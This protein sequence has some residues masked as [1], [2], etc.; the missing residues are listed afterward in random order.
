[1]IQ[2]L[3]MKDRPHKKSIEILKK[4]SK[5]PSME[6]RVGR[7]KGNRRNRP[8]SPQW[9]RVIGFGEGTPPLGSF[10]SFVFQLAQFCK[11]PKDFIDF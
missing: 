11:K 2:P 6:S 9:G 7:P 3:P 5:I 1:M 10:S 4:D 8:R